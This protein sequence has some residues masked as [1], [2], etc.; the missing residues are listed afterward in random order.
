M[1]V[2]SGGSFLL[3]QI[4]VVLSF[5]RKARG[6]LGH[7][8]LLSRTELKRRENAKRFRRVSL[9]PPGTPVFGV[10]RYYRF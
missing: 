6:N 5:P 9:E 3:K 10:E 4:N 7:F 8:S 1:Q 2:I